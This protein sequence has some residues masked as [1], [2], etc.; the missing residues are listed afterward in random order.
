M[1]EVAFAAERYSAEGVALS[2]AGGY[3]GDLQRH[4]TELVSRLPRGVSV[5]LG[6][7]GSLEVGGPVHRMN[8]FYELLNWAEWVQ[9]VSKNLDTSE[10]GR[11]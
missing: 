10:F 2:V 3:A 7:A 11:A 5:A 9:R 6:G 4:V 1:A 8:R